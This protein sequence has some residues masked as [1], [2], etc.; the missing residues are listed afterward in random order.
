[1]NTAQEHLVDSVCL[2]FQLQKLY[3][4]LMLIDLKFLKVDMNYTLEVPCLIYTY[5]HA[6]M[7]HILPVQTR[8][9]Y[10]SSQTLNTSL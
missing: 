6:W 1:M 10:L 7:I 9:A 4:I 2:C 5:R 3:K 8:V